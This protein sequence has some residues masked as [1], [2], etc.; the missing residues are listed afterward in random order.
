MHRD[1]V[2]TYY[3]GKFNWRTFDYDSIT[4]YKLIITAHDE[5]E[6]KELAKIQANHRHGKHSN[7]TVLSID[8]YVPLDNS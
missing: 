3:F 5:T 6:A 2:V 4:K 7:F 1:Y 8:P